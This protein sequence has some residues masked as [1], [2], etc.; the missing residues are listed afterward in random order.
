MADDWDP[1]STPG[2]FISR[3]ARAMARIGDGR[4]RHIGFATAQMPVLAMLKDG[5][6]MSQTELARWARVEQPT[7][8]QLLARMERD[9]L[10]RREPDPKDRRS[11]FVSLTPAAIA[12]LPAGRAILTEG[13]AEATK[14]LSAEQVATLI[15][16]L[17]HVIANLDAIES[18]NSPSEP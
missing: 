18:Q 6:R 7:M 9:G 2:H 8:A 14:G 3:A 11:S 12:K 10:V 16:L 5:A 13:N 4:L 1:M 17:K 15:G